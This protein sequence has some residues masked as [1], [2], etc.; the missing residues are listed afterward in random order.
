MVGYLIM[1][2]LLGLFTARLGR[3]KSIKTRSGY[4]GAVFWVIGV[5][6]YFFLAQFRSVD[7]IILIA[8]SVVAPLFYIINL[9]AILLD[10]K[11]SWEDPDYK[12]KGLR[13]LLIFLAALTVYI[14][15]LIIA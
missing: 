12:K 5:I 3:M 9:F 10:K 4:L 15:G 8:V 13:Y 6:V 11:H 2:I 14:I 1:L 7:A